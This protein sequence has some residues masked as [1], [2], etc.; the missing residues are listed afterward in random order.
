VV[1]SDNH[2]SR[3]GRQ[4]LKEVMGDFVARGIQNIFVVEDVPRN[5]DERCL[6]LDG[7]MGTELCKEGIKHTPV[8]VFS[9]PFGISC[10]DMDIR[11]VEDM[12]DGHFEDDYVSILDQI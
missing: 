9:R 7:G 10:T 6:C 5:N 1:P 11:E 2:G 3:E 4:T 12:C 8:F